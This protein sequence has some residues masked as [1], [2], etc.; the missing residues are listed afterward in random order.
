MLYNSLILPYLNYCVNIW[1][2]TFVTHLQKIV[3]L[4]KRIIR[5]IAGAE[6]LDHTSPLKS[7]PDQICGPD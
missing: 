4:Q 6:Q 5:M 2:N 3:I 7:K 1:D